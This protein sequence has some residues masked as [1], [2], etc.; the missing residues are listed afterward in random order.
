MSVFTKHALRYLAVCRRN[1]FKFCFSLHSNGAENASGIM[2][3]ASLL[4]FVNRRLLRIQS[5]DVDLQ[6]GLYYADNIF[7]FSL[8]FHEV[9]IGMHSA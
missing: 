8:D 7:D 4:P 3:D 2:C 6:T 1:Y 9:F 5:F